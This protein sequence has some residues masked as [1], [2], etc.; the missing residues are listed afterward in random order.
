M[1][2]EQLERIV[3]SVPKFR[4]RWDSF[5]SEWEPDGEPPWYIGMNE[6]AHYVVDCQSQNSTSELPNLFATIEDILQQ[7]DPEID[8]LI[9]IGLFED[10]Q[11]IASHREFGPVPFRE[12]LGPRSL[13]LGKKSK[14]RNGGSSGA[15]AKRWMSKRLWR[16]CKAQNSGRSWNQNTDGSDETSGSLFPAL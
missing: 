12:Q 8:R 7:P 5:L 10:I 13:L 16:K 4:S 14:D 6:L 9:T 2:R 3:T 15:N 1:D 11:N